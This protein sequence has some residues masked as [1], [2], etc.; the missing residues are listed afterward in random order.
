MTYK[1]YITKTLNR[2]YISPDDIEILILNQ[3]I[4]PEADVDVHTAKMA[5]Y[6]EFSSI[7][8]VAN[9]SEGGSSVTWITENVLT[10]YSLLASELG[11]PDI[12]DDNTVK[13]LS[14]YW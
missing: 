6:N 12:M 4:D 11:M 14:T 3:S 10:W 9:M 1:E 5:I 13:D 8:P 7:L 2:F